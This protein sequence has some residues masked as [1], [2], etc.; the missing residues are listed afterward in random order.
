[1]KFRASAYLA[2]LL[3]LAPFCQAAPT[4]GV[5]TAPVSSKHFPHPDRIRYDGHCMTIEGRDTFVYSAA[6]HYFR[7]PRE[8]WRDRFQKI[9]DAGF[10]AVETYAPWNWHERAM[11][12]GLE[13]FSKVDLS[14]L[15]AWL[16]MA[17]EEFGFHTIVRPGPFICAEW[18]GGGYPRWLAKFAPADGNGLW[19]RSAE[20]S[21]IDW[22]VHW[23]RA[24]CKVVAREQ[25]T[26]K[27]AG[28]KGVIMLQLENEYDYH[29]APG[30]ERL[31][32]AL[33]ETARKEGVE[34]PMFTCLTGQC[35]G[36]K[37]AELSQ[38][39]DCDNQYT[40][41]TGTPGCAQRIVELRKRQPDA[42][43]FV[44]ELQG[45]WFATLGGGLP[46]QH[47]SD[48]RHFRA[49]HLMGLLGGATGLNPYMFVGGTHFGEWGSRGQTTSYDYNAAIREWGAKSPKYDVAVGM[50]RFI[51][52]NEAALLRSEGG[53]CDIDSGDAK[54]FGGIRTAPDGTRFVF[55]LNNNPKSPVKGV[56][57]LH[58]GKAGKP[59]EPIYNI[60]Q[61]GNKV[62]IRTGDA[63]GGKIG[64]NLQVAFDL[65]PLESKVL[66]IPPEAKPDA[67]IWYPKPVPQR[68]HPAT[69][70]ASV[71][72]TQASRH[73]ED[74]AVKWNPL[75]GERSLPELG[76]SDQRYTLYRARFTLTKDELAHAGKLL[77]ASYSR[78]IVTALVN[79]RAPKRTH[80]SDAYAAAAYRNLDTSHKRIGPGD[81]DNRFDTTGLL[82]EGANEVVFVYENI[83]HE[84]G[85]VP[86]EELSG[87]R[88]ASLS[89]KEDAG[90]KT[91]SLE[92]ATDLSGVV[93]GWM[94]PTCDTKAW[95]RVTLDPKTP[96]KERGKITFA[97]TDPGAGL[98]TWWRMEFELP[99]T[100]GVKAAWAARIAASGNGTL[101]LNGHDIGRHHEVGS[102][103]DFYL[104]ECWL[105]TGPGEKNVL[106]AALRRTVHGATI[107]GAEI[108]PYPDSGETVPVK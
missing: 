93:H 51:R 39:F 78:D 2:T 9:K 52:E 86:M 46:D 30:K 90:A 107:Q 23:Y 59:A 54:L 62:L 27:P 35:R 91:L 108:T 60:D 55:L 47:Y 6:F 22:C 14:E 92:V 24:V 3:A 68:E 45:G 26:R 61:N 13:D 100:P 99:P 69:L 17:Q 37:D 53:P 83:G 4:L 19:L 79:G 56:A 29:G 77:V 5:T 105:K 7:T 65:G 81:F 87:I 66:V 12:D 50:S 71:R 72:L 31:L 98:V 97:P 57:T 75:T 49:T 40:G 18:A 103:R 89:D 10:N 11:P 82:R 38:V 28:A 16:K 1:M 34:V 95:E 102:Q 21:H 20:T 74:F 101:Y 8:L 70:P 63:E 58:P 88:L 33:Y 106:V 41:L 48:A 104:P 43:A 42:P 84:H 96:L 80:P 25:L 73:E 94:N 85:Y 64:D 32:K 44:T 67:G 76:V 15:E 36:S